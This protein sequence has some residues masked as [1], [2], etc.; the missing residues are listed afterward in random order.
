MNLKKFLSFL[1]VFLF[2][3]V[4]KTLA[5]DHTPA[6]KTISASSV[7]E[8]TLAASNAIDGSTSGLPWASDQVGSDGYD[9]WLKCDFEAG[10][11][12]NQLNMFPEVGRVKDWEIFGSNDDST[13]TSLKKQTNSNSATLAWVNTSFTNSTAYRYYRVNFYSNYFIPNEDTATTQVAVFEIAFVE[14]T[15]TPMGT[16]SG[17]IYHDINK[18]GQKDADEPGLGNEVIRLKSGKKTITTI[19]DTNGK[20]SLS[21]SPGTYKVRVAQKGWKRTNKKSK[22]IVITAGSTITD[23]NIGITQKK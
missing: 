21:L 14:N 13:W 23:I 17:T 3:F 8:E 5:V 4:S 7:Y 19:T 2:C 12:V 10:V 1:F 15:S 18:N 16:V 11:V 6:C 22:P 20:Y 9:V